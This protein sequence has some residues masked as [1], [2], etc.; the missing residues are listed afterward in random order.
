LQRAAISLPV[1]EAF[2]T[3]TVVFIVLARGNLAP[4]LVLVTLLDEVPPG[5][6]R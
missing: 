5:F 3:S 4:I 6:A 2:V 1:K